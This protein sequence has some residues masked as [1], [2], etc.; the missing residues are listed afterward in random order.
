VPKQN[1]A[2]QLTPLIIGPSGKPGSFRNNSSRLSGA[3]KWRKR[4]GMGIALNDIQNHLRVEAVDCN[5]SLKKS[6]E[7]RNDNVE[8]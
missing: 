3:E 6:I 4:R 7:E 8:C 5:S 1:S 2:R